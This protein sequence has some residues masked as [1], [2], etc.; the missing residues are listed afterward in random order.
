MPQI[1]ALF[2]WLKH[3]PLT[4]TFSFCCRAA[5]FFHRRSRSS[6]TRL[7][8]TATSEL[9]LFK[10]SLCCCSLAFCSWFSLFLSWINSQGGE[11]RQ[12]G[13]G[14]KT[15]KT[16]KQINFQDGDRGQERATKR[17]TIWKVKSCLLPRLYVET[18][19][20]LLRLYSEKSAGSSPNCPQGQGAGWVFC[21]F[22]TVSSTQPALHSQPSET[23]ELCLEQGHGVSSQLGK[24]PPSQVSTL[25]TTCSSLYRRSSSATADWLS[26]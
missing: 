20:I 22:A 26:W 16:S 12:E 23:A 7:S 4:G 14:K 15:T 17:E 2:L 13:G 3:P 10:H 8:M 9:R 5:F 6:L 25:H 11:R 18:D 1:K 19:Y 21:P 24:K